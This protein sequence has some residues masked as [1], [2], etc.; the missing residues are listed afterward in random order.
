MRLVLDSGWLHAL[1][2]NGRAVRL[3]HEA[4]DRRSRLHD[5]L[6]K[7][8]HFE[9][10]A[11]RLTLD[12][13]DQATLPE[14]TRALRIFL[15]ENSPI[16]QVVFAPGPM[17]VGPTYVLSP[18]ETRYLADNGH[19]HP[20]ARHA[21]T[22]EVSPVTDLHC[23]F[24]GAPRAA[25][26]LRLGA[27]LDL[28]Y[29][30]A[31]LREAGIQ[32]DADV[33]L[34]SLDAGLLERLRAQLQ[35]SLDRQATFVEMERVYRLRAPLTKPTAMFVPL[36]HQLAADFQAAGVRYAELSLGDI[37]LADRL[38]AAEEALPQ[39][40]A[41]TGVR[42]RFLLALS[43]H[44]DWEWDQ[45][46]LD[47]VEALQQ[48]RALVGVDFMG[49][50][51][52]ST[53]AFGRQLERLAERSRPGFV[54]R[55]H[56]GENPAHPENVRAALEHVGQSRVCLRI[57]HGLFG[58]DDATV[59]AL[60]ERGAFVEFN[61]N[62]NFALNNIQTSGEAPLRRYLSR[63]VPCVL[64]TDGAGLYQTALPFEVRAARLC[65]LTD[66]ELKQILEAEVAY[67]QLRDDSDAGLPE[68][69]GVPQDALPRHFT[70]AVSAANRAARAKRDAA[71]RSAIGP[72]LVEDPAKALEGRR[73]VS[74]A[75]A[76][77]HAWDRLPETDRARILALLDA[78]LPQLPKD[79]VTLVT[80]GTRFGVEGEVL[81]RAVKLGLPVLATLV[82]ESPAQGLA[83]G[84]TQVCLV[85]ESL[86][87]KAAGLYQLMQAHDGLCLFLG[88]GNVVSDEIQ[89]ATNLRLRYLLLADVAGASGLHA[90]QQ[91]HRAFRTA[92]EVL[93]RLDDTAFFR[94]AYAPFW[95]LGR[96]PTV[97]AV[98]LRQRERGREV[99][100]IRRDADAPAEPGQWALPGGF[101]PTD[102]ARGTL[103][104][105]GRETQ[106]QTVLREVKEETG[107]DLR[108]MQGALLV[109]GTFEGGGRDVR[110][111][112]TAWSCTT[113]FAVVADE[114]TASQPIAGGDDASQ[115]RWWPLEALPSRLA[116]D[117]A[118]LIKVAIGKLYGARH[119]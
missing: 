3:V 22:L 12:E 17:P 27:S 117:H 51:T 8:L 106:K 93:A 28:G 36:L 63:G 110:D 91:P 87:D 9:A 74:F 88:G 69:F 30:A 20:T 37:H 97:D 96:N 107:L 75:G 94:A 72:A 113:L 71:L 66:G 114:P 100:L 32:A 23:H 64:A 98:V 111:T 16:A 24:A 19:P 65:G 57:G 31:L 59:D 56:A 92:A 102:A 43:R 60:A 112:P 45:D 76:W 116:F 13:N 82:N 29:P 58:V 78:L 73:V 15:G 105:A 119:E 80:G 118:S 95:H 109:M 49:H 46:L 10:D 6:K 42:M 101:V 47:R 85:G 21:V 61:L 84:L 44:N 2:L 7:F 54:V 83:E 79:R 81:R 39:I 70:A 35:L 99:L 77:M 62:S 1:E 67:L 103:W 115:A 108:R 104:R 11:A 14:G 41:S 33:R 40:E 50:E 55:V 86:H 25:D 89:T 5:A 18:F 90:Q 48:S 68:K 34:G 26:L 38:R 53:H 4:G 52:N